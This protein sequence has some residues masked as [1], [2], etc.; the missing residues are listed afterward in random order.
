MVVHTRVIL[1]FITKSSLKQQ[2]ELILLQKEA[3]NYEVL[4]NSFSF[5]E[6]HVLPELHAHQNMVFSAF[7]SIY[8]YFY[9][10]KLFSG[11]FLILM[12]SIMPTLT[13]V[14]FYALV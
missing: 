4:V 10:S 1:H 5:E 12:D 6:S 11:T 13:S 14:V 2:S 7:P 3:I 9:G 8:F